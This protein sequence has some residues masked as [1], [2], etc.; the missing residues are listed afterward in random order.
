MAV[1]FK[2]PIPNAHFVF[3]GG[4]S[5]GLNINHTEATFVV[6][7]FGHSIQVGGLELVAVSDKV[8]TCL[9]LANRLNSFSVSPAGGRTARFIR[10]LLLSHENIQSVGPLL[11]VNQVD[12]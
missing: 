11:S 10:S 7:N 9:N 8:I 4:P 3:T 6:D 1:R 12:L 5:I 2:F